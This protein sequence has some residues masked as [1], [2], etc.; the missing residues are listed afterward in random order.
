MESLSRLSQLGLIRHDSN[1]VC[2]VHALQLVGVVRTLSRVVIVGINN[3]L[4][5][6]DGEHELSQ[7]A[8]TALVDAVFH[9]PEHSIYGFG[10]VR[11]Q[12]RRL[13]KLGLITVEVGQP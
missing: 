8:N 13:E 9:V 2:V 1:L 12:F 11:K 6:L 5:L 10:V 4:D 7:L 3:T